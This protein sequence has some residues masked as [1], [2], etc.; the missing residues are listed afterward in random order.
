MV[1]R[2]GAAGVVDENQNVRTCTDRSSEELVGGQELDELAAPA[3]SSSVTIVPAVRGGRA[4][5]STTS[6]HALATADLLGL[7]A[8]GRTATRSRPASSSPP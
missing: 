4:V 5:T 7:T 8:R 3:P 2:T 6:V 1:L